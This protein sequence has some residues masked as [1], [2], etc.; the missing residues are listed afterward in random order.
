MSTRPSCWWLEQ[1]RR[2]IGPSQERALSCALFGLAPLPVATSAAGRKTR[3]QATRR[4]GVFSAVGVFFCSLCTR[5]RG[6]T[7]VDLPGGH[8]VIGPV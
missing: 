4:Y 6:S 3:S 8:F 5:R 2:V 1:L 7:L